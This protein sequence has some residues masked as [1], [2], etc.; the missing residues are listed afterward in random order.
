MGI[1]KVKHDFCLPFGFRVAGVVVILF[2]IL[3]PVSGKSMTVNLLVFFTMSLLGVIMT[4]A[5]YGLEIDS[6]KKEFKEYVR[7]LWLKKG[8]R[9]K[10]NGIEKIFINSIRVSERMTTRT[11]AKYDIKSM[12]YQAYLKFDDGK[13]IELDGNGDKDKLMKRL[14]AYNSILKTDIQDNT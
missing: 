11:G 7:L 3:F 8:V 1:I 10:Y 6:K 12:R 9:E 14:Y 4:T 2:G 13:K 5:R